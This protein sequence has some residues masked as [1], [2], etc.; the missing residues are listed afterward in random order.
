MSRYCGGPQRAICGTCA[1]AP[2][3]VRL[4][5]S[6]RVLHSQALTGANN[7]KT[8]RPQQAWIPPQTRRPAHLRRQPA[9][10]HACPA[11]RSAS[12]PS[13]KGASIFPSSYD[14]HADRPRA[15]LSYPGACPQ[16][17]LSVSTYLRPTSPAAPRS[18]RTHR[19]AAS[20]RLRQHRVHRVP[21]S[22]IL[23]PAVPPG[24]RTH[25]SNRPCLPW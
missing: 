16:A 6:Q 13:T 23:A 12:H 18:V 9:A 11:C 14:G 5:L 4:A 24:Q 19:T 8:G 3:R 1:V 2:G 7:R 22:A 17:Y 20:H 21:R 15:L 10:I 25:R